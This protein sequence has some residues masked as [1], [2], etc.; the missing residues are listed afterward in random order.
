MRCLLREGDVAAL[1]EADGSGGTEVPLTRRL[2]F[3]E[4]G[5]LLEYDIGGRVV[6]HPAPALDVSVAR[7]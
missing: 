3:L 5:L 7:S 6:V 2:R 1:R 4:Q